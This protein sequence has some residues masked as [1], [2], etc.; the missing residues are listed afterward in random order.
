[1][2]AAMVIL[3]L[4]F[5]DKRDQALLNRVKR[6]AYDEELHLVELLEVSERGRYNEQV[7][8][9]L[10]VEFF[11]LVASNNYKNKVEKFMYKYPIM[12]CVFILLFRKILLLQGVTDAGNL[13]L[14]VPTSW[15]VENLCKALEIR[16]ELRGNGVYDISGVLLA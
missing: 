7:I 4:A 5:R 2:V 3:Q 11:H 16:Y 14:P 8:K 9:K 12:Q 13:Q 1:M 10:F 15:V 6:Y